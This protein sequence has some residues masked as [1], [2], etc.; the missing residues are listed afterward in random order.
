MNRRSPK[1]PRLRASNRDLR[2][3]IDRLE[4]ALKDM[5]RL[6]ESVEIQSAIKKQIDEV[7]EASK[8]LVSLTVNLEKEHRKVREESERRKQLQKK[9]LEVGIEQQRSMGEQLHDSLVQQ[10]YAMRT[11]ARSFRQ[12]VI[13][14][15]E[16]RAEEVEQLSS[17]LKA[18]ENEARSLARGLVPIEMQGAHGLAAALEQL[19]HQVCGLWKDVDCW[20]ESDTS[21]VLEDDFAAVKL[22]YIAREA[23]NNAL[24][25]AEP[26]RIIVRL[27]SGRQGET[28]LEVEDDGIGI[29]E[30]NLEKIQGLG[31]QLMQHRAELIGAQLEI[32]RRS[33]GGTVVRCI[34][35]G[36]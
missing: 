33:E 20:V 16:I 34:L 15:T 25:H 8:G 14:G 36:H 3:Y 6:L 1:E 29:K 9:L 4:S 35:P 24:R 17:Y 19:T 5:E 27:R 11:V 31:L 13:G 32:K 21:A 26:S 23:L 2:T 30:T 10:L 12:K 7:T 28:V 18:A 22:Y